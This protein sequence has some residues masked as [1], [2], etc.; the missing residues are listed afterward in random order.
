MLIESFRSIIMGY[1]VDIESVI[2]QILSVLVIIALILPLHEFAH[3]FVAVKLGDPTPKYDKRLTLNPLASIDPMGSLAM[4]LFGFGWAKPVQVNPRNFKSPKRDMAIV[5]ICGPISNLL[6]AIVG[7]FIRIALIVGG[8]IEV[9]HFM[10]QFLFSYVIIN[11]SL[12]VFNLIPVPP[13]DGSR[14]VSAFLSDRAMY[15]YYRYQ[16]ILFMIFFVV[17][18]SGYLSGPINT[19]R[20]FFYDIIFNIAAFP[21]QLAGVNLG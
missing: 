3:G 2:A 7:E 15:T 4:L 12:A 5:A 11:I 16:N 1:P 19:A 10:S 9:Q 18:F 21:F 20:N 13:L 8:L 6:A 14:V 17:M